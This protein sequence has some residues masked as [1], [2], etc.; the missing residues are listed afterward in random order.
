MQTDISIADDAEKRVCQ[1]VQSSIS[2]RVTN[3]S[4]IVLDADAAQP[5]MVSCAERVNIIAERNARD[6]V[7]AKTAFRFREITRPSELD[8]SA[9][10]FE[11][12][13]LVTDR[14]HDGAVI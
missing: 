7:I 13:N 12:M 5:Y 1:S 4:A 14:A 9:I 10:S 2:I 8:V 11:H 6:E 3:K